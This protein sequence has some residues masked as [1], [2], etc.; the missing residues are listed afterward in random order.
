[1]W[2]Y[3]FHSLLYLMTLGTLKCDRCDNFE[4]IS[5][6]L[7]LVHVAQCR[8]DAINVKTGSS[9][10][11]PMDVS[12]ANANTDSGI[13]DD[14]AQS[15]MDTTSVATPSS[16]ISMNSDSNRWVKYFCWV[17]ER[18]GRGRIHS[19]DGQKT[20]PNWHFILFG[21]AAVMCNINKIQMETM[22]MWQIENFSNVMFATW[23]FQMALICEGIRCGIQVN[24]NV[25]MIPNKRQIINI[26][27][28]KNYQITFL[29]WINKIL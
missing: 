20:I 11:F 27:N 5:H 10:Q 24:K 22:A 14:A 17:L 25:N 13:G 29:Y 3:Y 7:L 18:R 2:I 4:T 26:N 1:M 21:I 19:I 6:A 9:R 28:K 23:N 8:G 15:T 12:N 16:T